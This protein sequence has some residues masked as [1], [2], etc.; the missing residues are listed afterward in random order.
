M[1][2]IQDIK[3]KNISKIYDLNTSLTQI[4]MPNFLVKKK[5]ND[6]NFWM[7]LDGFSCA[8]ET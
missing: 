7:D 3:L 8:S 2:N 5:H 1:N 4:L 6:F